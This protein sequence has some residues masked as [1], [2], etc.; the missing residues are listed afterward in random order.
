[1]KATVCVMSVL[2]AAGIAWADGLELELTVREPAGAA[3]TGAPVS[4]GVPLP[5]GTFRKGQAFRL[6]DGSREIPLQ[7]SPLV[8]DEQGYLRWV[9]LDFQTDLKPNET[10]KFVLRSAARPA[11]AARP[12]KWVSSSDGVAVDTGKIKF[13]VRADRPFSLFT[14]VA[15][16]DGGIVTGGEVSYTDGLDSKRYVAGN[17]SSIE[18]EYAGPLRATICVR[19]RFVG[20]DQSKL[21][22]IARITAWAGRSDVHVKYTLANSNPQH[23]CYRQIKDSS[24]RLDLADPVKKTLVGGKEARE[25]SAGGW[26]HQG[27]L[28]YD[29]WQPID[30]HVRIGD[31]EKTL[32][33]G[34]GPG[35]NVLGW[36]AADAGGRRVAVCDLYFADDPPR[37]L[38]G[39]GKALVLTGVAQR[40]DGPMDKKWPET[41]RRVGQPFL[42]EYRWIMD[43]S[44]LSSEY[45]IDFA[46]PAAKDLGDFA[47]RA[48]NRLHVLAPPAWYSDSDLLPIGRYGTGADELACYDKWGWKYDAKRLPT[49]PAGRNTNRRYIRY[50]DNHYE[51]EQ[52]TVEVLALLYLRSGSRRFFD[53]ANAWANN[54][55]DLYPWR[56]DGWRWKDGGVW[57][58][59]GPLGNRPQ[60][61]ADPVIGLRNHIPAKWAKK[62]TKPVDK[63]AAL[64]IWYLANS[65]ACYCH[66]WGR[67]IASWYCITGDRD[68]LEAAID[69][70]EQNIDAIRRARRVQPGKTDSFSRDFT[71][72]GFLTHATRQVVPTDP[73]VVEASEFLAKAYLDRPTR[74]PRG[75]VNGARPL[76]MGRFLKGA[77]GKSLEEGLARWVGPQGV[78]EMKR[79]GVSMDPT[80]QLTDP[81]SGAKWYPLAAPHTWMFPPQSNAMDL[82]YRL[83]GSEDAMDWVIAYGQA[84]ARVLYQGR[85][86]QLTYG[87]LLADFPLKGVVKDYASWTLPSDSKYGEGM[88]LSGF[89]SGMHPDVCARAYALCGEPL[90]RQRAY[91]YWFHSSHRGY[92]KTKMHNLGGVGRWVNFYG[93]HA[94]SVTF[95]GRTFY[96]WSHERADAK[97]P[98]AVT[99]LKVTVSAQNATVTFTAPRD[100][101]GGKVVRYQVKCSDKPIV[102]YETF[103]KAWSANTDSQ[104]TNWWMASNLAGEPAPGKAGRKESFTVTGA[105]DGAKY[106]AVR[107]FDDSSNRSALGNVARGR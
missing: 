84:A 52:D 93:V 16:G 101:G 50:E 97:A 33:T 7:V 105:G 36:L 15:G 44:H 20:D 24:I 29:T 28:A 55:M 21:G 6:F 35:D 26:V 104:V 54:Y 37:R 47:R 103:L 94:E 96:V 27:L 45:V 3:R 71:R 4:G 9:L 57:W 46:A 60:R 17:P 31:G 72:A 67:G 19:G 2:L 1:M 5:A 48:R 62:F 58:Y 102:D 40:W 41:K 79:L 12:L 8:V 14:T 95:T 99:D 107:S 87:L 92:Q 56:T 64:D 88:K 49:A 80:G 23:Y 78:A 61:A 81:K 25:L 77:K 18:L 75:L 106:F 11:V 65:K 66:N 73:F 86:G 85:H 39:T 22:Y 32:W 83:T 70:V 10:R 43:C 98:A 38:A 82:Y 34:N 74:E 100:A 68:A 51:T 13:S 30:G 42:S 69:N 90:L 63:P 89:L 53:F 59:S 76:N 91:D